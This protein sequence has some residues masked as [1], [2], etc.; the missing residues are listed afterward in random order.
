MF[1][2]LE[3]ARQ[4]LRTKTRSEA[5]RMKQ[6]YEKTAVSNTLAKELSD[7]FKARNG[8]RIS[9]KD[10]QDL[11]RKAARFIDMELPNMSDAPR[12]TEA[13]VAAEAEEKLRDVARGNIERHLGDVCDGEESADAIYDEVYTLAHD[14]LV[15]HGVDAEQAGRIAQEL[16]QGYA[17]P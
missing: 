7:Q 2:T 5:L 14:A 9:V 4:F 16:A 13:Q 10:M 8:K 15:D 12:M 6:R 1:T 3:E 11:C 17:Q